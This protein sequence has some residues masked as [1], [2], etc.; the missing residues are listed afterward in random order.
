MKQLILASS[1]PYKR[2][3][4]ERLGVKFICIDSCVNEQIYKDKINDPLEL[5]QILAKKKAES[6]FYHHQEAVI[7]G[8]DQ[9]C[10]F[11]GKILGK[12]GSIEK[13]Y[14]QLMEMQGKEHTLITSYC[15]L[16]QETEIIQ[17]NKTKLKM[18]SLSSAQVKNYLRA[19]NPIDCAGSYKLELKGISLM[20]KIETS[21]HTAIVGLPI[22]MLGNDL[23]KCGFNIPPT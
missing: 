6:I 20:E 5:T 19:D 9:I 15:L 23:I 4:L 14:E 11:Q 12:T 17:T 21:D 7:I 1:S 13:S 2:D 8:A 3:L 18:R 16:S 22:I 10:I